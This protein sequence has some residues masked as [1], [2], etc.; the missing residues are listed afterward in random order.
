[1]AQVP[2][3]DAGPSDEI[4][5]EGAGEAEVYMTGPELFGVEEPD[6]EDVLRQLEAHHNVCPARIAR[7]KSFDFLVT[8]S[9]KGHQ[10][11]MGAEALEP[12]DC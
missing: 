6:R 2:G 10:L 11:S 8:S 9:F 12:F 5:K 7:G 1:M 4:K 3:S